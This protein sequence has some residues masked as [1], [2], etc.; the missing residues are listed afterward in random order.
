MDQ[1]TIMIIDDEAQ[2]REMIR[3]FLE[4]ENYQVI[5]ATDGAHASKLLEKTVPQLII[6]DV[7]MP[8]VDGFTFVKN[9]KKKSTIPIIFLSAKGE[10]WDKVHG[11][12][13]GGD[14]YIVKPFKPMELLARIESLLRRTYGNNLTGERI[15]AGPVT[16]DKK[17]YEAKLNDVSLPLTRREFG[18]LY[19]LVKNK[20]RVY[21][22]EELLD[23][24]WEGN[25]QNSDRTVDTHVKTLR[26]K[27]GEF[28]HLIATVWGVGYKF[29][30]T[31]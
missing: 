13:L 26:L 25:Q 8:F 29:E 15:T 27:M 16:I 20:G 31:E 22:R 14:D 21:S 2:M 19:I 9:L 7:M 1:T 5:E 11:L 10:E 3:T 28:S 4:A 6:V 17:S 18:L 12:R 30:V 23:L 24:V